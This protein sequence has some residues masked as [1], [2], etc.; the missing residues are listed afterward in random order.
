MADGDIFSLDDASGTELF[1]IDASGNV[2]VAGALTVA[3]TLD[4]NGTL[5]LDVGT[6]TTDTN[7]ADIAIVVND[8]DGAS[9]A[10]VASITTVTTAH[11]SGVL[12]AV[13][14]K[15]TSLAGDTGGIFASFEAQS[16]DGGGTTPTHVVIYGAD[17][18]DAFAYAAASGDLGITVSADGMTADPETAQE[19]GYVTVNVGATAYQIPMYAA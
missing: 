15:V 1:A 12:S 11:T 4:V 17:A 7:G 2:N 14:G 13:V 10:L 19:A 3:G 18:A 5:D 6:V 16:T 8:A 9:K